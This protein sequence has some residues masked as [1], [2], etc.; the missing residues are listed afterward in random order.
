M[1]Q[2]S[3]GLLAL[4]LICP[5]GLAQSTERKKVIFDQDTDGI[6]RGNN[7]PL[8]LQSSS[9]D[10]LGV[11][12]GTGNRWLKQETAEVLKLL[13]VIG[14][15]RVP[16]YMGAEFP[17][18]ANSRVVDQALRSEAAPTR[19]WAPTRNSARVRTS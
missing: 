13:E 17:A 7:D 16:V 8:L 2:L 11:T 19:S 4:A 3:A 1:K 15:P 14:R 9:I 12:V 5:I 10:V 6:I 18:A